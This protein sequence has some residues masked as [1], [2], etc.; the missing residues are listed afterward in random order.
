MNT[1][2]NKSSNEIVQLVKML[3]SKGLTEIQAVS[4]LSGLFYAYLDEDEITQVFSIVG[5]KS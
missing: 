2:T 5:N 4:Y 1:Q 3:T